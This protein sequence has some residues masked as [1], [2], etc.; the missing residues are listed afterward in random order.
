MDGVQHFI[1]LCQPQ[2]KP[3]ECLQLER[4]SDKKVWARPIRTQLEMQ[5]LAKTFLQC[6]DSNDLY[7]KQL[8]KGRLGTAVS[9]LL[10]TEYWYREKQQ[11]YAIDYGSFRSTRQDAFD[12]ELWIKISLAHYKQPDTL[13]NRKRLCESLSAN[14][15]MAKF[16]SQARNDQRYD[17]FKHSSDLVDGQQLAY[18]ADP[19]MH[20]VSND[21]KLRSRIA[22]SPQSSRV[23]SWR[24]LPKLV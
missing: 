18:L 7:G 1:S 10:R 17:F 21:R 6:R 23:V 11:E 22:G 13:D 8:W 3:C 5:T 14:R 24:D 15:L 20:F 16:V 12:E 2:P 19:D 9:E 4:D